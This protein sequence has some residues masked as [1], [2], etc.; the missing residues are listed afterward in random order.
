MSVR[1]RDIAHET[2]EAQQDEHGHHRRAGGDHRPTGRL[3]VEALQNQDCRGQEQPD[4]HRHDPPPSERLQVGRRNG[5]GDQDHRRPVGG[6]GV[7]RGP[8]DLRAG[9]RFTGPPEAGGVAVTPG[10]MIARATA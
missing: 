1:E 4:G 2:H 6:R 10:P 5:L 7:A 9:P 8:F 3:T